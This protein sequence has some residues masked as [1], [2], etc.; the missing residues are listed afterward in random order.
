MNKYIKAIRE[1]ICSICIDSDENGICTLSNNEICAVE[2]HF[3]KIIEVINDNDTEN[4]DEL[5]TVL[6]EEV[7]SECNSQNEEGTCNL[8]DDA[9]CSLDRY[10][11]VIAETIRKVEAEN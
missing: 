6:R 7:C 3:P 1:N 4:I 5:V 2:H 9:N 10:F 8:R 11:P